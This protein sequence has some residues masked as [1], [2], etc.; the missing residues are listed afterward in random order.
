ME[1]PDRKRHILFQKNVTLNDLLWRRLN[2]EDKPFS[3]Y[4]FH[5]GTCDLHRKAWL[6]RS[7]QLVFVSLPLLMP[8]NVKRSFRPLRIDSHCIIFL[9]VELDA[10][11]LHFLCWS[12]RNLF[13][14][15]CSRSLT[16]CF[17]LF[18]SNF[19][20]LDAWYVLPKN[21]IDRSH[22]IEDVMGEMCLQ[23]D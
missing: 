15:N 9:F 5:S 21:W 7:H 1:R 12:W 11:S 18:C 20:L 19:A 14:F 23:L 10:T 3:T 22:K 16:N 8:A 17:P 2:F 4:H 6:I 13:F